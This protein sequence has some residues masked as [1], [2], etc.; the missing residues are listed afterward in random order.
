MTADIIIVTAIIAAVHTIHAVCTQKYRILS[1][2]LPHD[3]NIIMSNDTL[4]A[5][6]MTIPATLALS[7]MAAS[8]VKASD[9]TI[10]MTAIRLCVKQNAYNAPIRHS[11]MLIARSGL[12]S[13]INLNDISIKYISVSK[14]HAIS[15]IT[16]FINSAVPPITASL[17]IQNTMPPAA[18]IPIHAIH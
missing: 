2:D 14:K 18:I 13:F 1:F 8:T 17:A 15:F 12:A 11:D 10:G 4:Y 3:A 6:P 9:I 7:I 16:A 5:I